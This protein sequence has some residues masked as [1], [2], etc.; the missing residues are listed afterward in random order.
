MPDH[1]AGFTGKV[2]PN[3]SIWTSPLAQR[4]LKRR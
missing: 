4:E 3:P 2:L 1:W